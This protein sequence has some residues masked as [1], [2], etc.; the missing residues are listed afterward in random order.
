MQVLYVS[1]AEPSESDIPGTVQLL[2]ACLSSSTRSPS[3][4]FDDIRGR[5][6][7]SKD[8]DQ[9][10]N[11]WQRNAAGLIE[12]FSALGVLAE[13]TA[14]QLPHTQQAPAAAAAAATAWGLVLQEQ[15]TASSAGHST[16]SRP[17]PE[18]PKGTLA[19]LAYA[20]AGTPSPG[21]SM[22][23]TQVGWCCSSTGSLRVVAALLPD[24]L[25][26][27][28]QVGS[29]VENVVTAVQIE[30][31]V[32]QRLI[33]SAAERDQV[34][35]LAASYTG[36][37]N[38]KELPSSSTRATRS[39]GSLAAGGISSC[40]HKVFAVPLQSITS[41][42]DARWVGVPGRYMVSHK[43][44]GTR[45][46]LVATGEEGTCYLV[47][48]AGMVYRF[49]YRP[50]APGCTAAAAGDDAVQELQPVSVGSSSSSSD[51]GRSRQ[52]NAALAGLHPG[53]QGTSSDIAGPEAQDVSAAA[54]SSAASTSCNSSRTA[55]VSPVHN[56]PAGTVLDGELV[57]QPGPAAPGADRLGRFLV[58]DA[59]S[60]GGSPVW[61]LPLQ[62]RLR[63]LQ[64]QLRLQVADTGLLPLS[65]PAASTSEAD[66]GSTAGS[67]HDGSSC[68]SEGASIKPFSVHIEASGTSV[69]AAFSYMMSDKFTA[70][71]NAVLNKKQQAPPPPADRLMLLFKPHYDVTADAVQQLQ[72]E[73]QSGRLPFTT[74]G[75]V[76]TPKAMPYG[77][78]MAQLLTKWQP[79]Q[80]TAA[81][82]TGKA[83]QQQHNGRWSNMSYLLASALEAQG[84]SLSAATTASKQLQ[85]GFAGLPSNLVYECV[86]LSIDNISM[87]GAVDKIKASDQSPARLQA[88]DVV[89]LPQSVRWD[90]VTGNHSAVLEQIQQRLKHPGLY[91][92]SH[93]QLLQSV[94]EVQ[95]WVKHPAAGPAETAA[96]RSLTAAAAAASSTTGSKQQLSSLCASHSSLGLH[97]ARAVPFDELYA[98]I[99]AAV[100]AGAVEVSVDDASGL[101]VFCYNM[102]H[103]APSNLVAA[104]CRGLVLHPGSKSVVATPF[105]RFDNLK[106]DQVGLR[107]QVS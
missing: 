42:A 32:S 57:W 13:V 102:A 39:S 40:L 12:F 9:R 26:L 53:M 48:R 20:A 16:N 21:Q 64:Q 24:R 98:D 71:V 43:C 46:L 19:A 52:S 107:T 89:W 75:L 93:E 33:T 65:Q 81:D 27:G 76:F 82:L 30:P 66:T 68:S 45:Y 99:Q 5:A 87:A 22:W 104:M 28:F 23:L 96:D 47:N 60:I 15:A 18:P 90:K 55:A 88:P 63:Q 4:K 11:K 8:T 2:K 79:V 67:S 38:A 94:R 54:V 56:L 58:F 83:L 59:L 78:G 91:C 69:H 25:Q 10:Q 35:Q 70:K 50:D 101:E 95:Q 49:P 77:L 1:E 100:T 51:S 34:L 7:Y 29:C 36:L 3:A 61:Q 105:V 103:G 17:H 85:Q 74:D 86:Q 44:D 97:P 80:Q 14:A 62:D 73:A 31:V 92:L 37:Y 6:A 72:E 106:P 41:K 84:L